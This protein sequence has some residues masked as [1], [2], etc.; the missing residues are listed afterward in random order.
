A[1]QR[2]LEDVLAR[3][4]KGAGLTPIDQLF[5]AKR[6]E[7]ATHIQVIRGNVLPGEGFTRRHAADGGGHARAE[8]LDR[9]VPEDAA[10]DRGAL[11][12]SL[13]LRR[14]AVEARL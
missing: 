7:N 10:D 9:V 8:V 14:Q 11:Q 5:A 3:A 1:E 12:D 4:G 6:F 13:L 2:V